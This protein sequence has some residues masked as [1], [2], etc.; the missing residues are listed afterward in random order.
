MV[1]VCLI[2]LAIE[3]CVVHVALTNQL[4]FCTLNI[5]FEVVFYVVTAFHTKMT[6]RLSAGSF[7]K[8]NMEHSVKFEKEI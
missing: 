3:L 7:S 5:C 1:R 4:K 8:L 6:I 2:P